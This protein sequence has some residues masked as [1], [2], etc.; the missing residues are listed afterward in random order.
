MLFSYVARITFPLFVQIE[1]LTMLS[2]FVASVTIFLPALLHGQTTTPV[3]SPTE[4]AS[5]TESEVTLPVGNRRLWTAYDADSRYPECIWVFG[6]TRDESSIY[7]YNFND[8]N[9]S[10][11][12]TLPSDLE[13]ENQ[14]Q[15]SAV[16]ISNGTSDYVYFVR[17]GMLSM[18]YIYFL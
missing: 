15:P 1:N 16:L 13:G 6:G 4:F 12:D 8:A 11:W 3:S 14:V 10:L 18:Q 5:W 2:A 7:C 17:D 9:I